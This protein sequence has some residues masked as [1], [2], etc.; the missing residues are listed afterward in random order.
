MTADAQTA[1]DQALNDAVHQVLKA[2]E[3]MPDDCYVMDFVITGYTS[4]FDHP[5]AHFLLLK[6][7]G[8]AGNRFQGEGLLREGLRSLLC[9]C[10]DGE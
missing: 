3:L 1:A 7:N 9:T 2:Y 8:Q 6:D 4:S 5:P 10:G